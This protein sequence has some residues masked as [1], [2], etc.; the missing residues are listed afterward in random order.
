L[1]QILFLNIYS[2]TLSS[3]RTPRA[4]A[5]RGEEDFSTHPPSHQYP[6]SHIDSYI[7]PVANANQIKL[8]VA[9]CTVSSKK[10]KRQRGEKEKTEARR[11][12]E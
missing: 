9:A 1:C 10:E 6:N 2:A 3:L 7:R 4:L 8:R 12:P 11:E 5:A